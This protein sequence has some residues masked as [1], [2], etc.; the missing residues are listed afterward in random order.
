VRDHL[1]A[2]VKSVQEATA[3][4]RLGANYTL[5][6]AT[7]SPSIQFGCGKGFFNFDGGK[8]VVYWPKTE[9]TVEMAA[10]E[11]VDRF[12]KETEGQQ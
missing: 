7:G 10:E 5:S 4:G 3:S 11:A 9:P 2:F 6:P 1:I 8:V 12:L